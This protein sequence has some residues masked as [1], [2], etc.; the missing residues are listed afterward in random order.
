MTLLPSLSIRRLALAGALAILP[1]A[2][3]HG[4][5]AVPIP[6]GDFE[7]GDAGWV[8]SKDDAAGKL[9][10]VVAAAAHAGKLGLEVKA[11]ATSPGSWF[12]SPRTD[13]EGGK[14][15][16][17][18]FWV[19]TVQQSGI[20][21]FIN[22]FGEDGKPIGKAVSMQVPPGPADW[23]ESHLD[24]K[25]PD[26]A[27]GLRVAVHAF[28]KQACDAYFDDF[29]MA[30]IEATTEAAPSTPTPAVAS[31]PAPGVTPIPALDPDRVK[32]IAGFLDAQPKGI[33]P[34]LEDR[35]AWDLQASDVDFK[36]KTIE[37]AERFLNEPTPQI[38]NELWMES[39]RTSDRKA[40]PFIDRRRFR[41]ATW[42]EAEGMENKGRFIP[43]IEKEIIAICSEPTWVLPA[44]DKQMLNF[45]GTVKFID[46]GAG[47]TSW[48]LATA[49]SILT[50]HLS[51]ETRKLIRDECQKRVI[52]PYLAESRG[53]THLDWWRTNDFNW[54][55][56]VHGG[57]AGTAVALDDSAEER[58]EIIASVEKEIPFYLQG[59]P[60]D[61]YSMEGMGYWK[62][63]FGHFIMLSEAILNA[64]QGKVNL[65][66]S[67]EA[68]LV[69]QFPRRF[70][71]VPGIYPAFGDSMFGEEQSLWLYH[72][73]DCR[74]GLGDHSVRP[75]TVD[76]MYSALLY[77]TGTNLTFDSAAPPIYTQGGE[78]LHGHRIRDWF[79]D[80]QVLIGRLPEGKT[81]ISLALKGGTNGASHGHLDLGTFVV[82][83]DK[84]P[85]LVD[86]GATTY[87]STTFSAQRWDNQIIG[88][89]GHS[90]PKVA[91]QG[92]KVGPEH[93]ATVTDKTF[94]DAADS[95]TLDIT[96]GYVVPELKTLTR[97]FDY[98]REGQGSVTVTDHVE[99]ASAQ[100]FGTA[101]VTFG[102]A[103]EEKPGVWTVSS[104]GQ[105]VRVEITADGLPLT[106]TNEELK[107]QA[108]AGKVYRLGI[109]LNS[110]AAAA[111]IKMVITPATPPSL[112]S[113]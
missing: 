40:E 92:Q 13:V 78:A 37:R 110:P 15:Y 65:Y 83:M 81:G 3:C 113:P 82:V 73:I 85:V 67:E 22:F 51:P 20:G 7:G 42:I 95:V 18:T 30:P 43:A 60:K 68:R 11:D 86:P 35:K 41:I 12:Q 28:S 91:G 59:F 16:R 23:A 72:V 80:G 25:A 107:D 26:G 66:A 58:A 45:N 17:L 55:A 70:E 111:T 34:T 93:F 71:I 31:A 10:Q 44:H 1:I 98:S 8:A 52:Q 4:Q 53:E 57:V 56:V 74:Y 108:R 100:A 62:Y 48:T 88:S 32:E 64:T 50:T 38:S 61:G 102:T 99:F 29:S 76:G 75:T 19:K 46:L 89:Y 14:T 24:A 47:M 63:G 103:K 9:S 77:A 69:A 49:D 104:N 112:V 2:L 87:G 90:V 105:S 6:N 5:T 21:I 79:D 84:Q 101:L 97:K 36:T 109:D 94:T 54:N 27:T 106:V 39:C 96:K 33:G